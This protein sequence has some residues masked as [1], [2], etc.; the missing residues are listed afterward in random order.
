VSRL[1][2]RGGTG[3]SGQAWEH[4]HW[5]EGDTWQ[6]TSVATGMAVWE[7]QSIEYEVSVVV[8]TKLIF[9]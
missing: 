9:P 7:D 1:G 3:V 5:E 6:L 8:P 2:Q 4:R